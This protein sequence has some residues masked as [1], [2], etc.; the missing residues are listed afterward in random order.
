MGKLLELFTHPTL[1]KIIEQE[2]IE[3][4]REKIKAETVADYAKSVVAYNEARIAR[5]N[6]RISEYKTEE[7]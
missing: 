6:K 5:L 1:I 2:L 3:A 7:V 4:H